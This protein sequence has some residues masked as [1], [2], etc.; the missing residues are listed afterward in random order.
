MSYGR[1]RR[2]MSGPDAKL[3]TPVRT[4]AQ[5][6]RMTACIAIYCAST[7]DDQPD[8]VQGAEAMVDAIAERGMR[9]VY[10]GASVGLM[11]VVGRRAIARH[12]DITG[13]LPTALLHREA[14]LLGL[15]RA[16]IVDSMIVRKARMAELADAFIAL[17]GAVGTLDEIFEQWTTHY[18]QVHQKPI[19]FLDTGGYW[20][21]LMEAL[22]GMHARGVVRREHLAIPVVDADPTKLLQRMFP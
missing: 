22:V 20:T 10:G 1:L 2:R 6:A 18:I 3:S 17:P 12:V 8:L 13:I 4:T 21:P 19:G 5:L 16:E 7:A 9:I 15:T 14:G 11:G